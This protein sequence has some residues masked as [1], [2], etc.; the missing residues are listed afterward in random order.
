MLGVGHLFGY[1]VG[2]LDLLKYFGNALGSSQ[3]KQ[4]CVIA[5]TTLIL[6]VVV[7]CYCVEERALNPTE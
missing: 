7:T 5:S 6:C 3:F 1:F 2:T 4:I